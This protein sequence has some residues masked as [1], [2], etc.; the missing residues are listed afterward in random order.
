[1]N[2]TSGMLDKGLR[3]R[4]LRLAQEAL[5]WTV[6]PYV[7]HELPGWG[8]IYGRI[9]T[10]KHNWLWDGSR[11]R[12]IRGKL[13]GKLMRLDLTHWGDRTAFFLGRWY[14]LP[15]QLFALDIIRP[16]D[17]VVDVGAN[18][19]MFALIAQ[20]A[21]GE[22][23][24]VI[25]FEPNPIPA[26][27]LQQTIDS[28]GITN[29]TLHRAGLSDAN[30][31]LTLSIPRVNS[32]EGTFGHSAYTADAVYTMRAPVLVGDDA[33]HDIEPT[34]VKM[35]VEGFECRALH[36]LEK[37]LRRCGP[38]VIT[39]V[40]PSHLE[41]CNASVDALKAL[42]NRLG[43]RGFRLGVRRQGLR[44]DWTLSPLPP[45]DAS[46]DAAWLPDK[47]PGWCSTLLTAHL[48]Q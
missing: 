31:E 15:T 16:G 21:A 23:G 20:H 45:G 7:V 9:G 5:I 8:R 1:M 14:D 4:M 10:H 35:D 42:M 22:D 18:R 26:D 19:G 43:Y 24:R 30:A 28:N 3:V 37:T 34:L 36:G 44:Y 47:L 39:E 41:R 13:H 27:I 38:I 11:P 48:V 12:T 17:T 33:L 46:F 2:T 25:C 32:G 6:R 40:V 29:V